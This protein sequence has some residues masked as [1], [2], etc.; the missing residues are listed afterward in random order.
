MATVV[1][2]GHSRSVGKTSVVAGLIAGLREFDWT[3]VKITQYGH[4]VCSANGEACDCATG[5][6][7]W[8]ISEENDRGGESDTSRF[9]LA[10]AVR[11]LWVRTEQGKLAEA[12]PALRKR[13][14]SARN[15]ILESNSVL[16]FMRPDLYVTVLDPRTEDFKKSAQEFLD[17][18]GAV[19]LHDR[20]GAAWQGISLKPVAG[21]PVFRITPP[22]YVTAEIV[23]FVRGVVT[24]ARTAGSSPNLQVGSE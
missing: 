19:I 13:I 5:D 14:E 4:G 22:P 16:K 11:A 23:E 9:L 21:R 12:M 6:H 10:G 15:V 7:S 1:I 20:D 24:E 3:A 18:A 8:A 2:G 17:R